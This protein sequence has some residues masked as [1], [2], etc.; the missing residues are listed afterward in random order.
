M[1]KVQWRTDSNG[2]TWKTCTRCGK[3]KDLDDFGFHSSCTLG[4]NPWCRDCVQGYHRDHAD[5]IS[6]KAKD[7]HRRLQKSEAY[8]E[9]NSSRARKHYQKNRSRK[10]AYASRYRSEPENKR[11]QSEYY[12]KYR[13]DRFDDIAAYQRSYGKR[14]RKKLNEYEK[15]RKAS[16]PVFK[17]RRV[18]SSTVSGNL[19]RRGES[20]GGRTFE[21]IGYTPQDLRKHL[22]D[23]FTPE[24]SW[25]NYGS[26][27]S[28]D[29]V[30]PQ[31]EFP[32]R[33]L[34]DPLFKECW[35]LSNLRPLPNTDNFRKGARKHGYVEGQESQECNRR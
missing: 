22:E 33:D 23:L 20:K 32:Y 5:A 10:L 2:K 12:R 26:Y 35:K 9:S 19:K 7:R 34:D 18:V 6:Q 4:R 13:E 8:R 30:V 24:M 14:N 25:S 21:K 15:N 3:E 17:L 28:I 11:C 27:W 1:K 16:D 29:H 31:K